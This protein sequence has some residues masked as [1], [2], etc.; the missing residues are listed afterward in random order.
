M[1]H[2]HGGRVRREHGR[3]GRKPDQRRL[4][5]REET[6]GRRVPSASAQRWVRGARW[7]SEV[8]ERRGRG[9]TGRA[10]RGPIGATGVPA[11]ATGYGQGGEGTG[12]GEGVPTG[13]RGDRRG[14]GG[15]R[16]G[17]EGTDG[18]RRGLAWA[19]WYRQGGGYQQR[20]QGSDRGYRREHGGVLAANTGYR[21]WG[22]GSRQKIEKQS[23][24]K[25]TAKRT[26]LIA[27]TIIDILFTA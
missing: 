13:L 26:K 3:R 16:Q 8:G 2:G 19:R 9:G 4:S 27:E 18:A 6:T 15:Y 21:H 7:G 11:G 17:G 23:E 5:S 25:G 12:G 24:T 14:R 10:R 20:T 22:T 1:Q